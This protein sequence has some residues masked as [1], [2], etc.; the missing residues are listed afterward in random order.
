LPGV[1]PDPG[2]GQARTGEGPGAGEA[3]QPD[4]SEPGKG[5]LK[6]LPRARYGI[7]LVSNAK[8]ALPEAEGVLSGNPIYTVYFGVPES[9]RKWVLQYCTPKNATPALEFNEGAVRVLPR[10]K[11]DPPYALR[12]GPV[13]LNTSEQSAK[14]VPPRV[15]VYATF[16]AEGRFENSRIIRGADAQIDQAIL[17]ALRSWEFLPAFAEGEPVLVEALLGIPLR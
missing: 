8:G 17:A 1:D 9:P 14:E 10:K 13:R 16:D 5:R 12:K 3:G 6:P 11:L 15:V 2:R 7:I 4:G